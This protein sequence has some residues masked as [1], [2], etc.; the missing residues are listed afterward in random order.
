M[1]NFIARSLMIKLMILV[2]LVALVPIGIVGYLS[3]D[4]AKEALRRAQL[5]KLEGSRDDATQ[6][7]LEYL[8]QTLTH[9]Q[10]LAGTRSVQEAGEIL[11]FYASDGAKASDQALQLDFDSEKYKRVISGID[12]LF[13]RWM[14][15]YQEE[16]AYEDI[17]IVAGPGRGH[18]SYTLNRGRDLGTSLNEDALK[19][20]SLAAL[21]EKVVRTK[22]PAMVDFA[23]YEP[24]GSVSAF[25]GIPVF[26]KGD[27][28]AG[29]LALRM[30]H[31]KMD[32]IMSA[33]ARIGETGEAFIVGDDMKVRSASRSQSG[34]AAQ[35]RVDAGT[36]KQVLERAKGIGE[37]S[38]DGGIPVLCAWSSVGLKDHPNLGADFDWKTL[39]KIDSSNAF[40]EISSLSH[41]VLA[42]AVGIGFLAAIPAFWTARTVAGPIT[43]VADRATRVSEGDLTVDVPRLAR[44]DEV[45]RLA[46]AFGLMVANLRT[47][48]TEVMEGIAVLAKSAS[49]ISNSVSLV[50]S[51]ASQTFTAVTETTTTVEE[52]KHAASL[53]GEKARDVAQ[54]SSEA[55]AVSERGKQ[56]TADTIHRM[57]LIRSEMESIGET[58]IR[59]S[60]H[61]R[62][63]EQIMA[64]VQDLSDQSNLLA[65]NASIEAARAGDQGKGFAVVAAEIKA[66]ADQ[67]KASAQQVR[68]IL[69]EIRSWV[70][71][72][73]MATENGGKAVALG[74][75]QSS[76]AA[77]AIESLL[78]S[79]SAASRAAGVINASSDQQFQ[80]VDQ[81]SQAMK[82]IESAMSTNLDS[83][84]QLEGAAK[85]LE[86]VG[87]TLKG[88]VEKYRV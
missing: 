47:Q 11:L 73:V 30:G 34:A 39:T 56:A 77:E 62:A 51:T 45:G 22:Q 9:I 41:R 70:N 28:L 84:R 55:E 81:V 29:M 37:T 12:P 8:T 23:P 57:N 2:L 17:L 46:R 44:A 61:S 69:E 79:V 19:N 64:T 76:A 1:P 50:A 21:F 4:G 25:M 35:S 20:S 82:N 67:S 74:V 59:L 85:R 5:Q 3:F 49:E 83:T 66:L 40:Q 71:A 31:W 38:G 13:H 15:L 54:T 86:E 80:G 63:I 27:K 7:L 75:E 26:E 24:A 68:T 88:L 60:E 14:A 6:R 52:V 43:Q 87:H 72:V 33:A 58:V 78:Q 48:I 32:L 16:N 65:V 42:V 36:F 18:I 53:S 10:F